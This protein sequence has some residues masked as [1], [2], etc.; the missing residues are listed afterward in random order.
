[1]TAAGPI[2][3]RITRLRQRQRANGSWRIWWEPDARARALGFVPVE[4]SEHKLTWSERRARDLN[5]EVD[6]AAITGQRGAQ[7]SPIGRSMDDLIHNYRRAQDFTDLRPKTRDSYAK[8]L[9]TISAKWGGALVIDFTKPVV[10]NWYETL[11]RRTPARALALVRMLSILFARAER[12][13]WRAEG[14]NPCARLKLRTPDPRD[15]MATW[16]ELDALVTAADRIDLPQI[17]TACLMAALS[18][19]RQTD[20]LKAT[21]DEFRMLHLDGKPVWVWHLTRSKRQNEGVIKL[22]PELL[23]RLRPL[24]MID[25]DALVDD[26]TRPLL[27]APHSGGAYGEFLFAKHFARVR[28]A[29]A[30]RCPSVRSLQFR[31]LR[32][33]FG[34][35][36]MES[37]IDHQ[38]VGLALGNRVATNARLSKTYLIATLQA[39]APAVDAI[40]RPQGQIKKGKKG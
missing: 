4:L 22:H 8:N 33:T 18:G 39:T 34:T 6:R 24:L 12:I 28:A 13:G 36:S 10:N 31:D 35:W 5:A 14:S 2:T 11:R 17:G 23:D 7:A 15:R 27:T 9:D 32:R 37:G 3:R 25:A 20:I 1:V 19:Q 40:Q 21:T 38:R 30:R 16:A 26:D 29:A